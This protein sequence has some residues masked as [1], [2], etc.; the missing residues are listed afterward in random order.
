LSRNDH[1]FFIQ[2]REMCSLSTFPRV[3]SNELTSVDLL[4]ELR[5]A[6]DRLGSL[7]IGRTVDIEMSRLR[8]L[9]DPI[10]LGPLFAE[11]IE[12]AVVHAQPPDAI[13]VRVTRTGKAARIEIIN[14]AG[15]VAGDDLPDIE[16]AAQALRTMG[17]E[18]GTAGQ[19]RGVICW[20]TL[21]L[22]PGTSNTAD[23]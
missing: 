22:A 3:D 17:G 7:L 2:H 20:I 9:A 21:P 5:T 18:I 8:V 13:T 14:D 11:L 10:R 19:A 12:F 1:T 15:D 6:L 23:V 4:E 16:P